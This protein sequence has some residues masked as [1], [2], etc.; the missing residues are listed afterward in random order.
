K[1]VVRYLYVTA[2]RHHLDRPTVLSEMVVT[3]NRSI[4]TLGKNRD[5]ILLKGIICYITI[6]DFFQKDSVGGIPPIFGK[7]IVLHRDSLG[8]H[9]GYPCAIPPNLITLVY[10]VMGKHKM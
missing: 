2:T 3:N 4:D 7:Y 5:G 1:V 6:A 8:V 9:H 10:I